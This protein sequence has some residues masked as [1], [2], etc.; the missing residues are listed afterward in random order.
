[1]PEILRDIAAYHEAGHAVAAALLGMRVGLIT[2]RPNGKEGGHT[3][4][5]PTD[6]EAAPVDDR[7]VVYLAGNAGAWLNPAFDG[8]ATH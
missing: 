4:I 6:F 1:M 5:E 2:I 3:E 8:N 7:V